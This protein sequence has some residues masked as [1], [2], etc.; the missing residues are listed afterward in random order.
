VDFVALCFQIV[1]ICVVT[2]SY[3]SMLLELTAS[4]F[5]AE[6]GRNGHDTFSFTHFNP[7]D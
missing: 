2:R 6:I 3:T 4:V 5:G 1:V 7:E